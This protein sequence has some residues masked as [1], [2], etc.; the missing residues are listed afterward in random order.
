MGHDPPP[1]ANPAVAL[2][3]NSWPQWRG[4]AEAGRHA[5]SRV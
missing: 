3:V 5:L 4:V 2:G 1:P